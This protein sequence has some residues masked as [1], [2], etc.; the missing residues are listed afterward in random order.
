VGYDGCIEGC[1]D[2]RKAC[3]TG[4][5][6]IKSCENKCDDVSHDCK[7]GCE[8]TFPYNSCNSACDDA[9][10]S[11]K[12]GAQGAYDACVSG[13][14]YLTLTGGYDVRLVEVSGLG[15]ITVT[16]AY[17][18]AVTPAD[19][20]VSTLSLDMT[21]PN[22]GVQ[23]QYKVWQDPIPPISGSL[24]ISVKDVS[25]KGTATL[26]RVCQG[27]PS[28]RA[29]GYYVQIDALDIVIPTDI[30]DYSAWLTFLQAMGINTSQLAAGLEQ[31][32]GL[33]LAYADGTLSK[34]LVK[35]LNKILFSMKIVDCDC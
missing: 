1:D 5:L 13:C 32:A 23:V 25:G 20:N 34:M 17:D 2:V 7:K 28:G 22:T 8:K 10:S 6:G 9:S 35:E 19:P 27:D 11:C 18:I 30:F 4:C 31:L 12:K 26:Y 16:N 14:G 3:K 21:V 33:F 15:A 29:S 24:P